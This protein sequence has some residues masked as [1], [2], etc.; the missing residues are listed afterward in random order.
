MLKA[1]SR[2]LNDKRKALGGEFIG[3]LQEDKYGFHFAY[4]PDYQGILLS[5]I[6]PIEQSHF[7][8][9]TLFPYFTSLIPEGWLKKKYATYQQINEHD[10]F[11][12]LI[13]NGENMLCAV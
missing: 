11:R 13:N 7:H 5:L 8:S 6:L 3:I 10:L 12:F 4:N 1:F 9:E 2:S